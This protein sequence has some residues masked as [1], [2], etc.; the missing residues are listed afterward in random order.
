[1]LTHAPLPTWGTLLRASLRL[2]GSNDEL[3]VQ[4]RG[5]GIRTGLLSRSAWSLALIALWRTR[6]VGSA[7]VTVWI[8]AYFCNA[9]LAALRATGARLVFYPVSEA[10]NPDIVACRRIGEFEPPDIFLLV[11]YFGRPAPTDTARDF[12][13]RHGAW[14]AEDAA[15]VMRPV[16]GV[17]QAGDFVLYSPHKHFPV[18]D[19]AIL[20]ARAHGPGKLSPEGLQ[21]IGDPATWPDQLREVDRS[22]RDRGLASLATGGR[23]LLKRVMQKFGARRGYAS[24]A[25]FDESACEPLT[26]TARLPAPKMSHLSRRLLLDLRFSLP[27]AARLRQRHQLL[28]DAILLQSDIARHGDATAAERSDYRDWTPYLAAYRVNDGAET[29]DRWKRRGLPV[30]TWPDLPPE[31]SGD[32]EHHAVAWSLRHDRIYLPVHQSLSHSDIRSFGTPRPVCASR[33]AIELIWDEL[34]A[35]QWN[36]LLVRA[37]RSNLLQSWSYGEAKAAT[38]NWRV[39]RAVAYRTGEPIAVVQTLHRRL[40][41]LSV[42]RINRG[43]VFLEAATLDDQRMIW[44][45]LARLGDFSRAR[46][47]SAAPEFELSGSALALLYDL[48]FRQRSPRAAESIWIDLALAETTLRQ[49]MRGSWKKVRNE[50]DAPEKKGLMLQATA[51]SETFE[52]MMAK[53][54]D[55]MHEKDFRGAPA[56]LIRELRHEAGRDDGLI[57]LRASHEG[58]TVSGVCLAMHGAA[59]TYLVGWTSPQG[60]KLGVNQFLLWF[61][62]KH[63]KQAG[64]RWFD[65]GGIDE[66][67]T[68]GISA[69]KLGFGGARYELVGEFVKW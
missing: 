12:C 38:S 3:T 29:Y 26:G 5:D 43:P 37:G 41:G 13:T 11:H 25:P 46:V 57:V 32:R 66:D 6:I 67:S 1:M 49:S 27:H 62:V 7:R 69:F 42:T 17:G 48:G 52:W 36:Q 60:R 47:L 45:E 54:E 4:W 63:L 28:W 68:P 55:L 15:H 21:R 59:A 24:P 56:D 34:R 20:V 44:K 50:L 10:M 61:G 19:G 22:V 30:T 14:L 18:P 16:A 64:F 58:E 31:V 53:Y 9:S 8:P 35:E 2:P 39:K 33:P 40:V 23:W 65:L 51:D